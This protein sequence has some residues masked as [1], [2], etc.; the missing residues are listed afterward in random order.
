MGSFQRVNANHSKP[1]KPKLIEL[2]ED[3]RNMVPTDFSTTDLLGERRGDLRVSYFGCC[4]NI[5]VLGPLA[6]ILI[7]G[8]MGIKFDYGTG[9]KI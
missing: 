7:V 8:L 4:E 6:H 1:S 5:G 9:I 3:L 2:R